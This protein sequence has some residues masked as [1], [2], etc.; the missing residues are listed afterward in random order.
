MNSISRNFRL[1]FFVLNIIPIIAAYALEYGWH[2]SPCR[3]CWYQRYCYIAGSLLNLCYLLK[4]VPSIPGSRDYIYRSRRFS[5]AFLISNFAIIATNL[6]YATQQV[7]LERGI[8]LLPNICSAESLV[9]LS[10]A[11]D[12]LLALAHKGNDVSCAE[13]QWT[14]WNLSIASW[15]ALY[16]TAL[17]LYLCVICFNKRF[18]TSV[19]H[20]TKYTSKGSGF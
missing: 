9:T 6:Y 11:Q 10:S 13:T 14:F 2:I 8:H 16:A 19:V 5:L 7:L 17:L 3:L 20:S 1:H 12:L 4:A 18:S 15:N